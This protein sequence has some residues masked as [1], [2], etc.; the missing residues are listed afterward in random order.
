MI[1]VCH[2]ERQKKSVLNSEWLLLVYTSYT[3]IFFA[4]L[5]HNEIVRYFGNLQNLNHDSSLM[6]TIKVESRMNTIVFWLKLLI[7]SSFICYIFCVK[8]FVTSSDECGPF[9]TE[10]SSM[11]FVQLV[12]SWGIFVNSFLCLSCFSQ[13]NAN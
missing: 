12:C 9:G 4:K 5:Y 13:K 7:F 1:I 8:Q 10:I 3:W 2:P 6:D 11:W